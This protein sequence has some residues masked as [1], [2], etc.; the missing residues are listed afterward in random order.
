MNLFGQ[1]WL[2]LG[3]SGSIWEKVVLNEQKWFYLG[4]SCCIGVKVVVFGQSSSIRAKKVVFE[5]SC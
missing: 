3:K 2:Y 5:Q 4:K 1:K